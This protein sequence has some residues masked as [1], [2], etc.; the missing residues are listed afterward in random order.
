MKL[1]LWDRISKKENPEKT[2]CI[3]VTNWFVCHWNNHLIPYKLAGIV[4]SRDCNLSPT[5]ACRFQS[6]CYRYSWSQWFEEYL[7]KLI[8]STE[9]I[10]SI[11][12]LR[13]GQENRTVKAHFR[14]NIVHLHKAWMGYKT[15]SKKL[16]E[17]VT[18]SEITW[19][20]KKYK[21]VFSHPKLWAPCKILPHSEDE[22][23][24]KWLVSPKL[25][26]KHLLMIQR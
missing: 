22:H 25:H 11:P 10:S 23:G 13:H 1:I 2:N 8:P 7:K 17:K 26:G 3:K 24:E 6:V 21:M 4:H 20:W 15:I 16:G 12:L 5:W 18:S 9:S 19:K 14:D